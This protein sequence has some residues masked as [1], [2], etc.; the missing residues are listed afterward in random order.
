MNLG[1]CYMNG[2]GVNLNLS[3]AIAIWKVAK[4]NPRSSSGVKQAADNNIKTLSGKIIKAPQ[5][6][7]G[8]DAVVALADKAVESMIKSNPK[9]IGK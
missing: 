7:A 1:A 6:Q 2:R 3:M 4:R 5:G 8:L 9:M